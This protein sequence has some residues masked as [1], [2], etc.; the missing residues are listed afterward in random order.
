MSPRQ[1]EEIIADLLSSMG[2]DV[3]LTKQTR[4]GGKDILAYMNTDL[5][6]FLCLVGAKRHRHDRPV[7][8]ALVRNLYGTLKDHEATSAMLVTTSYFS[9]DAKEFQ[10]RHKFHFALRDYADVVAW[11]Q[12][13]KIK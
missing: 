12:K 8:I 2:Y 11:I 6:R 7:G 5:G 3:E 1:F 9:D 13:Y 10:E 4:D